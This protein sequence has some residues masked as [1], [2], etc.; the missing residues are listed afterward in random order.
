MNYDKFQILEFKLDKI[1]ENSHPA[2]VMIAK[3]RSG[4]SW[5][6]RDVIFRFRHIPGGVVIS[7]TDRLSFFYKF[8]FPDLYIHYD[9]K[10][11]IFTKI[12]LRQRLM[13]QK[14]KEKAR[15]GLK[16][17]AS[18]MLIMDDC[19]SHAKTW[20]K[21]QNIKEILMNGRHYE[22]TYILTMQTPLGIPPDLR[23]NFDYVFLL[24]EDSAI[25]RKKLYDNYASCFKTPAIFDKVFTECTKDY[26]CMVIDNQKNTEMV[27]D[28]VFW[29]K[30][31]ER[32]FSFGSKKFKDLHKKYYD[33]HYMHKR[34]QE[35]LQVGGIFN[36][37]KRN[38]PEIN[39]EKI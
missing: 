37:K 22:L 9:I 19:L 27:Q 33:P 28:K 11:V 21:D 12:L 8:F 2:I 25:N 34:D 24:M 13:V 36:P 1:K 39:V 29:F 35:L 18:C 10:E 20:A 16:V 17:D 32:K 15:H 6:T 14:K 7:P 5:V 38:D 31:K 30:A 3:R 26:C 23:L 4:K